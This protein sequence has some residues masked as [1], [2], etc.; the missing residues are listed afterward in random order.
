MEQQNTR[1][2]NAGFATFFFSGIC[3]ISAG[4]VVSLLQ[5]RYGFAYGMTGTLL[6]LMSIGNLL[7]GLL[8]GMLPSA[9]GMKRSVLLLTIGYAVGYAV[10]GLT[11]AVVLLAA[12]FFVVGIAKGSV[13]NTCTILVSDHSA[14]RTR[15]MNTMHACYAC[16]ALLC[17]FLISAA[18]RVSTT[19][20]VLALAALCTLLASLVSSRSAAYLLCLGA[21]A[22]MV[23]VGMVLYDHFSEPY[24]VPTGLM[25]VPD[26]A[27]GKLVTYVPQNEQYVGGTARVVLELALCLL[28]GGQGVLLC[29]QGVEHMVLLPVCS[30]LVLVGTTRLGVRRFQRKELR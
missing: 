16:G 4:V 25:T 17:P 20:A 7:A 3:A 15:G 1:L 10:M 6:S 22:A 21:V 27:T 18:A 26:K 2:R 24:L 8:M 19:L 12:A 11:G 9:L 23:I 29:E 13:I 5:E 28:P 14:D 30:L